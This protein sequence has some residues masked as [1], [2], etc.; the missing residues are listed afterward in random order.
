MLAQASASP[1]ISSAAL[2]GTAGQDGLRSGTVGVVPSTDLRK[3][4]GHSSNQA[5]IIPSSDHSARHSGAKVRRTFCNLLISNLFFGRGVQVGHRH[6]RSQLLL[7]PE[8]VDHYVGPDN[9]VRFIDAFVDGLDL[10][11]AGFGHVEPKVTGRPA[12][13]PA[14]LLKLY[15]YGYLNRC[16]RAAGW[17]PKPTAISR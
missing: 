15:I 13:P 16:D 10:A 14:D 3:I 2:P 1:P 4:P 17:K 6:D 9:P 7:L 11:A 12:Y 8:A 5:R